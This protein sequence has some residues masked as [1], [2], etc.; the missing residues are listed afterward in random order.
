MDMRFTCIIYFILNQL[1]YRGTC[2]V[3]KITPP[4]SV[5]Y[6]SDDPGR[7]VP[8]KFP[9]LPGR[10]WDNL[11]NREMASVFEPRFTNRRLTEDGQY[12]LP[13]FVDLR[14]ADD[15]DESTISELFEHWRDVTSAVSFSVNETEDVDPDRING[16][17]SAEFLELKKR[18]LSALAVRV[19]VDL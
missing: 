18:L 19:Q 9:V 12:L 4:R 13:D 10:G 2:T 15:T 8:P 5:T 7:D 6:V 3:A 14:L 17:I 16:S 11:L 1:L